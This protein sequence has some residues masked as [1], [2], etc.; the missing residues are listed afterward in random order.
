MKV[1]NYQYLNLKVIIKEEN[2]EKM[3]PFEEVTIDIPSEFQGAVIERLGN[4]AFIM[5]NMIMHENQVRLLLKDQLG[6]L[7]IRISLSSTLKARVFLLH[8]FLVLDLTLEKLKASGTSSGSMIS[9]VQGKALGFSL[10]GLQDRGQLYIT[11]GTEVY[12]GMVI[13]N[14]SKGEKMTGKPN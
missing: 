12:E 9:M 5:S 11:A 6:L 7:V 13:G 4:R 2:G 3:E 10:Y 14:T 8:G 1:T